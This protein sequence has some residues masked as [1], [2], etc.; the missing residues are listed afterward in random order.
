MSKT[1]PLFDDLKDSELYNVFQDSDIEPC[2]FLET[3]GL[4]KLVNLYNEVGDIICDDSGRL[5]I[6]NPYIRRWY[7]ESTDI[8]RAAYCKTSRGQAYA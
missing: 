3:Y 5:K 6:I 8:I 4:C 1:D 2:Q 7:H